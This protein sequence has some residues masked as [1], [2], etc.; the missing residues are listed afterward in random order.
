MYY[1][2]G[3]SRMGGGGLGLL[4]MGRRN[5]GSFK[6]R[7][8]DMG[9]Q[10]DLHLVCP[11]SEHATQENLLYECTKRNIFVETQRKC[12]GGRCCMAAFSSF[13]DEKGAANTRKVLGLRT[14]TPPSAQ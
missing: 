5:H 10:E 9:L 13:R 3:N 8:N 11:L 12:A 2:Q 6:Q 4:T 1:A 7:L 14:L